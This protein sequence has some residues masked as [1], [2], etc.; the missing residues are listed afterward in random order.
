MILNEWLLLWSPCW[1]LAGRRWN[2]SQYENFENVP[3]WVYLSRSVS[4]LADHNNERDRT[5]PTRDSDLTKT[6]SRGTFAPMILRRFFEIFYPSMSTVTY[7]I[8]IKR[9]IPRSRD[10][11]TTIELREIKLK[12][13][14]FISFFLQRKIIHERFNNWIRGFF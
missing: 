13:R 2:A 10:L 4:T 9:I 14:S 1:L 6:C 8:L 11:S 5:F 12:L 3:R 7:H